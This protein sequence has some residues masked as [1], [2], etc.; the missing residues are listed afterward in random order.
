MSCKSDSRDDAGMRSE[1]PVCPVCEEEAEVDGWF[2][3]CSS[4]DCAGLSVH[5]AAAVLDPETGDRIW[6]WYLNR[7]VRSEEFVCV[8]CGEEAIVNDNREAWF[9]PFC[10]S[11]PH[12]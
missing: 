4:G 12:T 8:E 1:E 11:E 5:S 9:C 2:A 7:H 10:L 3:R 6:V